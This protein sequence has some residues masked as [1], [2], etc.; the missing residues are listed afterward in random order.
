LD[1]ATR[2]LAAGEGVEVGGDFFEV[3]DAPDGC[4]IALGDVS[5]KG[6]AAVDLNVLARHTIR[7]AAMRDD[8]PA[9]VLRTLNEAVLSREA[10]ERYCTAAVCRLRLRDGAGR[11]TVASGG[12][13]LPM[14]L[15]AAGAVEEVGVPGGLLGMFKDAFVS[16]RTVR[17]APGDVV[18]VYSDGVTEERAGGRQ[19]GLDGLTSELRTVAGRSAEQVAAA[20]EAAVRSFRPGGELLDDVAL[21]VARLVAT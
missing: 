9:A 15:R 14:V 6:S 1:V 7:A 4:W 16:E 10:G 20:V 17:L 12:H 8:R 21:V 19:F 3:W 5:G 13:P 18:V 2:Y 11:L